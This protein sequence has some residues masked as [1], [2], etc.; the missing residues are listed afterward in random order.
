VNTHQV[1][2]FIKVFH[3]GME[4]YI[5][6]G[7][8][9]TEAICGEDRD[10]I[11][12]EYLTMNFDKTGEA[13]TIEDIGETSEIG[14]LKVD[15][16]QVEEKVEQSIKVGQKVEQKVEQSIKVGQKVEQKVEQSIK[17]GQKVEEKVEQSIKVGQKVEQYIKA[18]AQELSSSTKVKLLQELSS[19]STKVKR[20]VD[21]KVQEQQ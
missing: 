13:G 4:E 5:R 21:I 18:Q 16:I 9:I 10:G 20:Q 2:V 14:V 17:V 19:R 3:L 7:E 8:I 11:I 12:V 15:T 6:I 1:G